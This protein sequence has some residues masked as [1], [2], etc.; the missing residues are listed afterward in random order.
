MAALKPTTGTNLP[1]D[2]LLKEVFLCFSIQG[3]LQVSLQNTTDTTAKTLLMPLL[4]VVRPL[5]GA[6]RLQG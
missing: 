4:E 5:M 2:V 6:E 3:Y 1:S